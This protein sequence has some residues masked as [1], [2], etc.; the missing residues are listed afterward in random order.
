MNELIDTIKRFFG[1]YD[2][3]GLKF[4][5]AE[6]DE[7]KDQII[8]WPIER[9]ARYADKIC[10]DAVAGG[11][12]HVFALPALGDVMRSGSNDY[13]TTG[14][15]NLAYIVLHSKH[16]RFKQQARQILDFYCSS[17]K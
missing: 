16:P 11:Y 2:A 8:H 13:N 1:F 5:P 14:V 17:A 4:T 12:D 3:Y 15:G 6:L 10:V 7:I 9:Q